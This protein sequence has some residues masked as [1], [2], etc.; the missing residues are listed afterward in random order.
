MFPIKSRYVRAYM[1]L[2][3][4]VG[5]AFAIFQALEALADTITRGPYVQSV[6]TILK[7]KEIYCPEVVS[8]SDTACLSIPCLDHYSLVQYSSVEAKYD[9]LPCP[10]NSGGQSGS[11][12]WT[13]PAVFVWKRGLFFWL[14]FILTHG[15]ATP[16]SVKVRHTHKP[17]IHS[18]RALFGL[19]SICTSATSISVQASGSDNH[20]VKAYHT[21]DRMCPL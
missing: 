19:C 8:H 16:Q 4:F 20:E 18:A 21:F 7:A 3:R 15:E 14:T 9:D 6:S 2:S 1:V 17:R 5:S 13:S 10:H 11:H 12:A